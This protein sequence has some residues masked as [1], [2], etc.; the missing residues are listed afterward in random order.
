MGAEPEPDKRLVPFQQEDMHNSYLLAHSS[1]EA[2]G[3]SEM[4]PR[5]HK[6][7]A[8]NT[9][10]AD[11]ENLLYETLNER[12]RG[13]FD[14]VFKDKRNNEGIKKT[15]T[16]ILAMVALRD[17]VKYSKF[18]NFGSVCF[19]L[20][21]RRE[22]FDFEA[23]DFRATNNNIHYA[24]QGLLKG[25]YVAQGQTENGKPTLV[26]TTKLDLYLKQT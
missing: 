6:H 22:N 11:I 8:T 21:L 15:A 17:G 10:P 1:Y 12:L 26:A 7:M 24:V 19:S 23:L 3:L 9:M 2:E 14:N 25:G 18:D 20:G 13:A 4:L 16:V 5:L